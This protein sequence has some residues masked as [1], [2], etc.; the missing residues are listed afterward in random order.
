MKTKQA[1]SIE[2]I[3]VNLCELCQPC[4][5]YGQSC[6]NH[7]WP[8]NDHVSHKIYKSSLNGLKT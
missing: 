8:R 6:V 3:T 4:M 1:F 7:G 2:Q 5:D